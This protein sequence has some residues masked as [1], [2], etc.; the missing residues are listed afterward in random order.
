MTTPLHT[1]V[2][3]ANAAYVSTFGAKANLAL[4]PARSAAFL[5]C[6]D[7][8][9]NP[10]AALG[11][12]EGDAHV[13]RNAGG[14]ASED[15]IRS[16]VISHK[17]LGT[18]EWFIIQHTDCGMCYFKSNELAT[19]LETSLATADIVPSASAPMGV[20]FVNKTSE[21]GSKAGHAIHWLHIDDQIAAIKEDVNKV[22]THELVAAGIP[23]HGYVYN[24][25]TGAIEHVV[26]TI[27]RS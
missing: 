11:L 22:A 19:L 16:F 24:V 27:S 14:R 6:M 1:E 4:P 15:A 3:A 26:S 20:T 13:I 18:K 10:A 7:A 23:I 8:R 9:I 25:K 21:G 12:A 17:L 2:L 5:I